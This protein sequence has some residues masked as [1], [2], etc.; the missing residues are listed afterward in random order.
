MSESFWLYHYSL[1]LWQHLKP[2]FLDAITWMRV[3]SVFLSFLFLVAFIRLTN[4][5]LSKPLSFIA[6]AIQSNLLMFTFMSGSVSYDVMVHLWAVSAILFFSTWLR[7]RSIKDLIS[8]L[9]FIALG[10]LTKISFL[11]LSG[12]LVLLLAIDLLIF[13]RKLLPIVFD[14]TW[15]PANKLKLVILLFFGALSLN[16]VGGNLI[17]YKSISPACHDVYTKSE[18]LTHNGVYKRDHDLVNNKRPIRL[19]MYDYFTRWK[20]AMVNS[21]FGIVSGPK[22]WPKPTTTKTIVDSLN[23]F[24]IFLMASIFIGFLSRRIPSQYPIILLSVVGLLYGLILFFQV[25]YNAYLN[26]GVF[27]L[28]LQGRYLF[29]VIS[30]VVISFTYY[31]FNPI[32]RIILAPL[33]IAVAI[34][35]I[36]NEFIYFIK[37]D[38]KMAIIAKDSPLIEKF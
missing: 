24:A 36:R 27:H 3:A 31:L 2:E 10:S 17:K 32:P 8:C 29:P 33:A 16:L 23:L 20:S 21:I 26:S 6:V 38:S 1:G 25:N 9:L 5:L 4:N 35:F 7:Q 22:V 15:I 14:K 30:V 28:A 18:C 34:F 13:R 12:I 19:G 37:S 11:P